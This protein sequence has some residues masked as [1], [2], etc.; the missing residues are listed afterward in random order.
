VST[1]SPR[2]ISRRHFSAAV[3]A[4]ITVPGC[5]F[6]QTV[7]GIRRAIRGMGDGAREFREA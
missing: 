2:Q 7:D 5:A 6:G 1:L 3:L 4:G